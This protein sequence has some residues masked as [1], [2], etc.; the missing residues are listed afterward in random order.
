MKRTNKD[1]S[2]NSD[3]INWLTSRLMAAT[4]ALALGSISLAQNTDANYSGSSFMEVRK[5]ISAKTVDY[6]SITDP[7][8]R[9]QI[10]S[11]LQVYK[12]GKLPQYEVSVSKFVKAGVDL[13]FNSAKRT[14]NEHQDYYPRIEKFVH[15]S[16]I[17]FT[18]EWQITAAQTGY[19][20]YFAE[21]KKGLFIGRASSAMSETKASER[22]GFGFAGKIFP[23]TDTNEIVPT[24]NFFTVDVLPG[25]TRQYFT[26][27]SLTNEPKVNLGLGDLLNF[28]L[29]QLART[30]QNALSRADENPGF[31]PLYPVA[32]AG[33]SLTP[34]QAHWPH[35]VKLSF[36]PGTAKKQTADFRD[37]LKLDP[38]Q[39]H[40]LEISVSES[41]H[42]P[43]DA[44]QWHKI[45]Y[46]TLNESYV[47]YGCDRQLHFAH[48]KLNPQP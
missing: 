46:I 38:G 11:E 30:I 26:D 48:P 43:A 23:T 14:V 47:S 18:G 33:T 15:P 27:T 4:S 13:L 39:L 12:S 31:R 42:N 8:E 44:S 6:G 19:T 10:E 35:W 41:T 37:E 34:A 28:K 40:R 1:S 16:G 3:K 36:A 32:L 24:S 7:A 22:R 9:V 29:L 21:G 20:G 2:K 17:C 45:G 5:I 25:E